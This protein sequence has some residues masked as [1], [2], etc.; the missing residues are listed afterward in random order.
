VLGQVLAPE[1]IGQAIIGD[2][3]AA[4][5]QEDLQNLL[6]A[7]SAEVTVAERSGSHPDRKGTE[8][9]DGDCFAVCGLWC[10]RSVPVRRI[11]AR[12]RSG[13]T[14]ANGRDAEP[15]TDCDQRGV[16]NVA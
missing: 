3:T 1:E 6:G 15:V 10:H 13:A 16:G 9:G 8:E 14:R 2:A 7:G 11:D 4:G 5:G 12:L